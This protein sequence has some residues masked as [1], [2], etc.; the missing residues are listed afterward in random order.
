MHK[1]SP[2]TKSTA[3]RTRLSDSTLRTDIHYTSEINFHILFR[4][5]MSVF[6][7]FLLKTGNLTAFTSMFLIF[8]IFAFYLHSSDISL[9]LISFLPL[10]HFH[11]FL[12]FW[13]FVTFW[14]SVSFPSSYFIKY[15]PSFYLWLPQRCLLI[16]Q[17]SCNI[18]FPFSDYIFLMGQTNLYI[19]KFE[20]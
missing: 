16:S 12:F 19:S 3:I 17:W 4:T 13:H 20:K 7:L 9:L 2:L 5:K 10:L 8:Y 14:K 15:I 11:F 1:W 6:V 18:L